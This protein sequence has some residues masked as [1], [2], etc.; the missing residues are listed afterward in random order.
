MTRNDDRNGGLEKLL[1]QISQGAG[2]LLSAFSCLTPSSAKSDK[3]FTV[4]E[5]SSKTSQRF[6]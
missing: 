5:E 4:Q 3:V 1:S 2:F 6:H